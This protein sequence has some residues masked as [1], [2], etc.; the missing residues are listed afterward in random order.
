MAGKLAEAGY[1][2]LL[3]LA[4]RTKNPLA[5]PVPT[6]IGGFGGADKMAIFLKN[7]RFDLVIDATHPYAAGIS[8]NAAHACA[9]VNIP[10]LALRRA[11]WLTETGDQWIVAA[12]VSDAVQLL[13]TKPRRVFVA[14][15]RNELLP[16]E[17]APQHDYLIR[18]VD[19]IEPPL[20]LPRVHYITDRGPFDRDAELQLLIDQRIDVIISKNSGGSA[21]YG[22]IVAARQLGLP[23]IMIARPDLP[24]MTS[25]ATI[26]AMIDLVGH[27]FSSQ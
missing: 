22:K 19:P 3:S 5:Q 10:L 1:D 2:C 27:H 20:A 12:S 17:M 23:V 18:S 11:E 13:G 15:G 4:G 21:S 24:E 25:A 26:A 6:R 16:F 9:A 8:T 14:L 7:S